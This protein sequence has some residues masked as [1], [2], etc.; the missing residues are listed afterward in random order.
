MGRHVHAVGKK[1]HRAEDDTGDD[2]D[3]HERGREID[4]EQ[5]CRSARL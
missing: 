3:H 1:R 4:H 2:F 5:R